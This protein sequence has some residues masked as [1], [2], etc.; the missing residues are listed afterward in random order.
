LPCFVLCFLALAGAN[1]AEIIPPAPA[2][3]FNDYANVVSSSTANQ[4]DKVLEDFE[5]STSSQIVVA[6]YPQMQSGSSLEDY[7]QRIFEAWKVGQ[8]SRDNG[9]VLFVFVQE[10]KMRIEVGYGLE[11]ALP[12][13]LAKQIIEEQIKPAFQ[14]GD[15]ESGL[16]AGV[17]TMLAAVRGEYKGTGATVGERSRSLRGN[18]VKVYFFLFIFLLMVISWMRHS[19]GTMYNRSGRSRWGGG[20]S[21]WPGGGSWGG[22]SGGGGGFSGGFS[23]GGGRSGGGGA[24]GG[25]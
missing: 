18:P 12:D 7:C 6:I 22:G 8:K 15:F 11:G 10:R 3:Y 2:R 21:S 16:A 24:S 4:L 19:R 17:R 9:A 25:W 20:W 1:A 23:G 13:A 14:K 5:R